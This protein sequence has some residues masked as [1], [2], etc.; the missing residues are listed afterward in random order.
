[1]AEAQFS[2]AGVSPV[3]EAS[4]ALGVMRPLPQWELVQPL[5]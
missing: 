4:L 5:V 1:M 3:L 2:E